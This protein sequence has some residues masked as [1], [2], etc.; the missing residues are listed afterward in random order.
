[1]AEHLALDQQDGLADD[2]V[3]VERYHLRLS[4]FG[5][6]TNSLDHFARPMGVSDNAL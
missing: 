1:V 6:C 2:I 5:E 3:D 4:P